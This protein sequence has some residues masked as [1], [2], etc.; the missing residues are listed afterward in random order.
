MNLALA[1]FG[2]RLRRGHWPEYFMLGPFLKC[3]RCN[4]GTPRTP[5]RQAPLTIRQRE[6]VGTWA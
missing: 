4:V 3:H 2:H 6:F 5:R 1:K